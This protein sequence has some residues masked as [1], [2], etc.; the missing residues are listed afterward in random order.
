MLYFLEILL[1]KLWLKN[2]GL[3]K[4]IFLWMGDWIDNFDLSVYV[5]F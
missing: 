4:L 5:F 1:N 3:L 2:A